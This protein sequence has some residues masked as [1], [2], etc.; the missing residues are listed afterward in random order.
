M[1]SWQPNWGEEGDRVSPRLIPWGLTPCGLVAADARTPLT[2]DW[3]PRRLPVVTTHCHLQSYTD[4]ARRPSRRLTEPTPFSWDKGSTRVSIPS[5]VPDVERF[6]FEGRAIVLNSRSCGTERFLGRR[7]KS[8][9]R[10]LRKRE[11][12]DPGE[13]FGTAAVVTIRCHC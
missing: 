6:P 9:S 3:P 12:A 10:V 2:S 7:W 5:R 8:D 4:A 1:G 11:L 13:L